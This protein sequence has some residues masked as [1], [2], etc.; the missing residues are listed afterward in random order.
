MKRENKNIIIKN[1]EK[2]KSFPTTYYRAEYY[3]YL[4]IVICSKKGL[5][6]FLLPHTTM[7]YIFTEKCLYYTISYWATELCNKVACSKRNY[8]L[9]VD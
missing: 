7:Y 5:F 1:K 9:N 3:S 6:L 2:S 4:Q 8:R